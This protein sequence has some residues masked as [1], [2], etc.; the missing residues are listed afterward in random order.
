MNQ[1]LNDLHIIKQGGWSNVFQVGSCNLSFTQVEIVVVT[2]TQTLNFFLSHIC[3]HFSIFISLLKQH[4]DKK[5][6]HKDY[7]LP[8]TLPV[9]F[10][11]GYSNKLKQTHY[12]G[13]EI[14][15]NMTSK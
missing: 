6:L 15:K 1:A 11:Y 9:P 10:K 7:F 12:T 3:S 14:E 5:E 4:D 2:N 13:M 8:T